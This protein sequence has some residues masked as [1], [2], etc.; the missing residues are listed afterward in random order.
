VTARFSKFLGLSAAVVLSAALAGCGGEFV[1]DG[2]SPARLVIASLQGASGATPT[3]LG[4]FVLSDVLT[5]VTQGGSCTLTN[6]CPSR[7]ND[8]G[9][10]ELRLQ[11][12]DPGDAVS[13]SAPSALNAVTLNRYRVVYRRSDRPNAVEGVDVPYSFDGAVTITVSG[14]GSATTGFQLVRN[15]AKREAPLAALENGDTLITTIAEVTFYG[16]DQ[17]GNE[18]S[19]TGFIE[20]TFGNFGDPA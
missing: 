2:R 20:I 13:P 16:Q 12:R 18:V 5:M 11:L 4:A 3:E 10:V 19:V 15:A 9:Q 7:F 1:R 14:D 8:P 6:P 17:A